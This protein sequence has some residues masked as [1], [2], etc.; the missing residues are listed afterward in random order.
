VPGGL[1][2]TLQRL[3]GAGHES[4]D[5]PF[6][7][8]QE[9]SHDSGGGVGK[10]SEGSSELRQGSGV[11]LHSRILD[12]YFLCYYS[13]FRALIRLN[14]HLKG[15]RTSAARPGRFSGWKSTANPTVSVWLVS[16]LRGKK[17][18]CRMRLRR[19]VRSV[20]RVEAEDH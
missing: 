17:V 12:P 11:L 8:S 18:K 3:R 1:D 7:R 9:H 6:S 4:N 20:D 5:M 15:V 14:H 19:R 2:N 10:L 13:L 16:H